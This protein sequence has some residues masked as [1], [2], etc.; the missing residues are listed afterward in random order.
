[1]LQPIFGVRPAPIE[2]NAA[3]A[4]T[5]RSLESR[6]GE[7]KNVQDLGAVGDGVADDTAAIQA[8]IDAVPTNGGIVFFPPGT[9]KISVALS[10]DVAS[11]HVLGSGIGATIITTNSTTADMFAFGAGTTTRQELSIEKLSL[12]TSVTRTGGAAIHFNNT[13]SVRVSNIHM[14]QQFIGISYENTNIGILENLQ[15][16]DTVASTGVGIDIFGAAENNIDIQNVLMDAADASDPLAGIRIRQGSSINIIACDIIH[17]E[18]GLFII[19]DASQVVTSI[20]V[21]SSFFDLSALEGIH[22]LAGS[23]TTIHRISISGGW[24]SSNTQRGILLDGAGTIDGVAITDN[25][26]LLN[27]LD[28]IVVSTGENIFIGHNQI[29]GNSAASSGTN[30]GIVFG[31]NISEFQII[32]NQIGDNS[33]TGTEKQGRGIVLTAGTGDNYIIANNDMRGNVTSGLL[34][35]AAGTTVQIYGNLPFEDVD[36][37]VLG[38][39]AALSR[40]LSATATLDFGS[41]A[42]NTSTDLTI[43]VTGAALN[44]TVVLGVP[45]GSVLANSSYNAWVSAANTVTVRFNNYSA[46][47]LDPD[48]NTFRVDV[49]KH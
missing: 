33:G 19:P 24:A 25:R 6:F 44:D 36:N 21:R 12:N 49:W 8:A 47:T 14:S 22:L 10:I 17:H 35:S 20:Y 48:S 28:G 3:D 7:V 34:D 2:V 32:G 11:V 26:I 15:I 39:G 4:T 45:H 30:H 23:G 16:R 46:G 43:T 40:H 1:M 9:Y 13:A 27:D 5:A 31:A 41:T 29:S 18:R 38:N 42:T 37:F